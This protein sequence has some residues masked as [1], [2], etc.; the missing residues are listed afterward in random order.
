MIEGMEKLFK[1]GELYSEF[2][3]GVLDATSATWEGGSSHE[4][5]DELYQKMTQ[6]YLAFY[7]ESVGK[8]LSIPQFGIHRESL[9]ETMAAMDAYYRFMAVVGDFLLKFN[10]PLKDG[11]EVLVGT[12]KEREGTGNGFKS[13]KEIYDFAVNILDEKYDRYIKSPEGVQIVVNVVEKYLDFKKKSD[14]VKD[15]WFKSL[16]IPTS[17]EMED[18]YK[19]IYD[20][21]KKTRKQETIIRDHEALINNLNQK[22]LALEDA[23]ADVGK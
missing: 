7:E 6:R 18:V 8:F 1:A 21:R 15:I 3:K 11:L 14:V 23:L 5:P 9:Q 19:G 22:V 17:K 13:A 16:S 20:L 4:D 10:I 12:I 2:M